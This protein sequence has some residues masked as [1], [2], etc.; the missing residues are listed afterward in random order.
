MIYRW[1][2]KRSRVLLDFAGLSNCHASACPQGTRRLRSTGICFCGAAR[3]SDTPLWRYADGKVWE[4]HF[5]WRRYTVTRKLAAFPVGFTKWAARPAIIFSDRAVTSCSVQRDRPSVSRILSYLRD[6]YM[7]SHLVLP[8][9]SCECS[10]SFVSY[11]N[12]SNN[13]YIYI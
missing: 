4:S 3:S 12:P 13:K 8:W 6:Y 1:R 2:K 5:G 9:I 11:L 10:L 7:Y